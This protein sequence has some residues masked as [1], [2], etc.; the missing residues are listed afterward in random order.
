MAIFVNGKRID[1]KKEAKSEKGETKNIDITKTEPSLG[2]ERINIGTLNADIK[3]YA[4]DTSEITA[5]LYGSVN[6]KE[7]SLDMQKQGGQIFISTKTKGDS[8]PSIFRGSSVVI[9]NVNIINGTNS[10][11][12]SSSELNLDVTIPLNLLPSL[13]IK[14]TT[15]DVFVDASVS[16]E[17]INVIT[18]N[19]DM[20]IDTLPKNVSIATTNGDVEFDC[21]AKN[22]CNLNITTT[23]GDV[24]FSFI[25]AQSKMKF[26]TVNGDIIDKS[27]HISKY[28][29][30]GKVQTTN[31]DIVYK[32]INTTRSPSNIFIE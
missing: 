30:S 3:V 32:S 4:K 29:V 21:I 7:V 15:G 18:T 19:G 31:G 11:S 9:H 2:I 26:S 1:F 13:F 12:S 16:L 17:S 10:Y 23:N 14:S 20:E 25:D 5:R 28:I 27:K 6:S 24:S 8:T 22:D